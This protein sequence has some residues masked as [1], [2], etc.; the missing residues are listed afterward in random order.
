MPVPETLP[1]PADIAVRSPPVLSASILDELREV[2]GNEVD[3]IIEVYLE[4]APR[5]IAQLERAAVGGD[6][7]ALRVAAHT[8][9]SSSANVGAT[10]LSEAARDLEDGARDG[11]LKK[12]KIMVARI[13]TE[14]AQVRSAL[15]SKLPMNP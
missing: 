15:Q 1:T 14:F 7:I 9:K 3:K 12:P 5:L 8:L 10:T 2:L 11:T 13:V 4:D 6:P